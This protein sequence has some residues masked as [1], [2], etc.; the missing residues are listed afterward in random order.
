MN[1]Y[2]YLKLSKFVKCNLFPFLN[3]FKLGNLNFNNSYSVLCYHRIVPDNKFCAKSSPLSG[4]EVE[5]SNFEKQIIFLKQNYKILPLSELYTQ[6]ANGDNSPNIY[7]TFDDGYLDNVNIALP[8][9]KKY[10]VP[11]TF[12]VVDRFLKN[13]DFMWW[14]YLWDQIKQKNYAFINS[15]KIILDNIKSKFIFF[16]KI[17]KE[18]INLNYRDQKV[19]IDNIFNSK[20]NFDYNYLIYDY[21]LL[22]QIASE[23]LIEI[24]S[25]TLTHPKLSSLTESEIIKEIKISKNI[26]ETKLNKSVDFLAYPYGGKNEINRLV[27]KIAKNS[28]YKLGLSTKKK[29]KQLDDFFDIPRANI[30]NYINNKN[31]YLKINGFENIA[32][33][34]KNYFS[35]N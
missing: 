24:G 12:F 11:A 5:K 26:I 16:G 4:L 8:I 3:F 20:I 14:Y 15:K 32:D 2:N 27:M 7:I 21:Q 35:K 31:F 23:K 19:F 10:N 34:I 1:L 25:H 9:L 18:L 30:D 6:I 13:D 17:S 29:N 33:T 22:K 28:G